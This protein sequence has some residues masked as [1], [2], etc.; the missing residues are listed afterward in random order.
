MEKGRPKWW[1]WAVFVVVFIALF[2]ARML[3]A[4]RLSAPPT[5]VEL[6]AYTLTSEQGQEFG[7]T[8]LRGKPYIAN[9]V[10]TSCPSVCP[11]LTKRMAEIQERTKELGD[12]VHLVSIT[13]DPETD[14]PEVLRAYGEK[15]GAD[16]K[17]WTFLTGKLDVIEPVIVK[18]FKMMRGKKELSPGMFE[19]VHGERFVLV[20]AKGFVRGFY[21]ATNDGLDAL[22]RDTKKIVAN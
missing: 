13:V 2:S 10:F 17:R 1:L 9:F 12:A 20:D 5:L 18:G 4:Q 16:P 21:E 3:L 8:N 14:T 19:I 6:P 22:L 7:A 11:R 15:Y